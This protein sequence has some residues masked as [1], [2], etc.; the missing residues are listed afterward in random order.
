MERIEKRAGGIQCPNLRDCGV[1]LSTTWYDH[2]TGRD[3]LGGRY[4]PPEI[5]DGVQK[6]RVT[7]VLKGRE[8]TLTVKASTFTHGNEVSLSEGHGWTRTILTM[9]PADAVR[10]ADALLAARD[11]LRSEAS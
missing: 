4:T 10:L 8:I 7:D 9:S 2:Q 1:M 3:G 5:Y 6:L 11:E